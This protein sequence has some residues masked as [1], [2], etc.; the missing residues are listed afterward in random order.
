MPE[1]LHHGVRWDL[2]RAAPTPLFV[3]L[4]VSNHL[5]TVRLSL[6]REIEYAMLMSRD[7]CRLND[8]IADHQAIEPSSGC[9][10]SCYK[11]KWAP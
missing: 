5:E 1:F 10:G 2:P 6:G 4:Q 11:A 9:F 3:N 8:E 7:E